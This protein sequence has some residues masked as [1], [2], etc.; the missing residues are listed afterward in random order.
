MRHLRN[1]LVVCA[2]LAGAVLLMWAN[3]LQAQDDPGA[4]QGEQ[5]A[6]QADP[7]TRVARL[8]FL[9]GSVS[10][11]PAGESDWVAAVPNRP[12]T[13]GDSL[14]LDDGARAELHVGSTAIRLGQNTG[15]TLLE[16]S[17]RIVQIRLAQ[18]SM[19]LNARHVDD[20]DVL[21]ADTPNLAFTVAVPGEYRIDVNPDGTETST[22]V[23]RGQGQVNGGGRAYTVVA[24]QQAH[25]TGL[26]SLTYEISPVPEPDSFDG[27]ASDR[28]RREDRSDSANYV[29]R[30][31]TG[32]EDLDAHGRW[33]VVA[34]YGPVWR[35]VGVPVG[36]APYR[37]GHWV[38]IEPW[39]WTWVD[40]QPWGFAPFHYGRWA[41]VGTGWVWIPGPVVVR[42]VYAP[43]LVVFV[44]GG[45]GGGFALPVGGGPGVAWFPLGPGEV[46]VPAYRVSRVYVTQINVTNTRVPVERVTTVYNSYRVPGRRE[47]T[48]VTYANRRVPGGV[49]AVSRET[50]VRARPV[51]RNAVTVNSEEIARAPVSHGVA[52]APVRASVMGAGA[53][54]STAPPAAVQHRMV[55]S[56]RMP[57]APPPPFS[58]RLPE[59]NANPGQPAPRGGGAPQ[60]RVQAPPAA[61]A[62]PAAPSRNPAPTAGATPSAQPAPTTPS[63]QPGR[64]SRTMERVEPPPPA[65]APASAP[66]QPAARPASPPP[67]HPNVQMN[68]PQKPKSPEETREEDR[69]YQQYQKKQQQQQKSAPPKSNKPSEKDKDKDKPNKP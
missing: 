31:V 41:Y 60:Q 38:W 48:Q 53:P 12:L 43:A 69:K 8:N 28:D 56:N 59:L 15:V 30:E 42:P 27:W 65:P 9:Y 61:P 24:G 54:A 68:P 13:S 52:V 18:G 55:M 64:P 63:S 17:D 67:S 45:P 6:P 14:W 46:F 34:S 1:S 58:Q 23:W 39:G 57:S 44:G 37:Y 20:D 35:P 47:V 22:A 50:F 21:E 19:I 10:F 36:W 29:S 62:A 7:P 16:V 11:Q 26:D 49:T 5:G 51:G 66:P 2:A 25:F 32:Y 4:P 33:S 3:P 40:D